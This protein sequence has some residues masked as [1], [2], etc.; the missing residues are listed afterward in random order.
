MVPH[1]GAQRDVADALVA[2]IA[3]GSPG[4]S[5]QAPVTVGR[6]CDRCGSADHGRPH[7][8]GAPVLA[9]ISYAGDLVVVAV[10]EASHVLA[11]GI[12]AERTGRDRAE[13]LRGVIV[14]GRPTSLRRWTR[15]EAV[16]KADGRGLAVEPARVRIER[17]LGGVYGRIAGDGATNGAVGI[18]PRLFRVSGPR[19]VV[20]SLAVASV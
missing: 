11:V 7:V 3:S 9:S 10:A 2:D 16:L 1:G 4:A 6:R 15:V 18:R 19:G 14:P 13:R 12:D 5:P 8:V 17:S 20:I